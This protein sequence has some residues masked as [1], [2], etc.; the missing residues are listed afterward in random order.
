[1]VVEAS[2]RRAGLLEKKIEVRAAMRSVSAGRQGASRRILV[3]L[4]IVYNLYAMVILLLGRRIAD[5]SK[6]AI[7]CHNRGRCGS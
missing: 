5:R 1:M 4:L 3:L 7:H 6:V 2:L